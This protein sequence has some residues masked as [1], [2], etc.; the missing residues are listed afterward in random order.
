MTDKNDNTPKGV[1]ILKISVLPAG[2]LQITTTQGFEKLETGLQLDMLAY[3]IEL[4]AAS[5][6]EILA[7]SYLDAI[8][9]DDGPAN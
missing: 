5:Q 8:T 2:K 9:P 7:E 3:S 4:L 1:D 6:R